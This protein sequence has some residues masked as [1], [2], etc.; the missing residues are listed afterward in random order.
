M[1]PR[2]HE[3]EA[4]AFYA[5]GLGLARIPKPADM[6][7]PDGLWFALEGGELHLG[8]ADEPPPSTRAHVALV[9]ADLDARLTALGALGARLAPAEPLGGLRRVHAWDPFGNRLELMG[10]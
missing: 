3:Q 8:V 4:L 7:N 9:V 1:I 6:P 2:G 5:G 10:T